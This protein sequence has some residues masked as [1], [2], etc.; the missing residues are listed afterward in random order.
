MEDFALNQYLS[1]MKVSD[2]EFENLVNYFS[3]EEERT[4]IVFFGDH[5]PNDAIAN[6]I[7]RLN[8]I[9]TA[10][11]SVEEAKRRYQVP[12]VI[13]ANYDIKE[14]QDADTDISFLAAEVM[15]AAR[16][17]TTAYQKFL[18]DFKQNSESEEYQKKYQI[19]QY[20]YMFDYK[21]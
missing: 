20:Y 2:T 15:E 6:K 16:I 14:E 8:G 12:Y 19:V 10:N 4:I 3:M 5:Q 17:P 13:W 9:S 11:M 18:L 21:K 1:L 7:L